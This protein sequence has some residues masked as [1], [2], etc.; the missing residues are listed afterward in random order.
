MDSEL[1]AGCGQCDSQEP[2]SLGLGIVVMD[3]STG[4]SARELTTHR[5]GWRG[6]LH[7]GR[8]HAWDHQWTLGWDLG[9][10]LETGGIS[11]ALKNNLCLGGGC[12]RDDCHWAC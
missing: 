3:A 8:E 9:E 12:V 4:G 10:L 2:M 6:V 7:L 11:A 5:V 1:T